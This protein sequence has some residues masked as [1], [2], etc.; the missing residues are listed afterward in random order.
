MNTNWSTHWQSDAYF[1]SHSF[2]TEE[3]ARYLV[4]KG[5]VLVGIDSHNVDDTRKNSRPVHSI[6]LQHEILI[7][8]HL[9]CLD[10]LPDEGFYFHAVPPKVQDMGTFPVRAYAELR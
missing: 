4:S 10:E 5:V 9:C 7:D 1:E 3:A 6:L 8:E 2:L